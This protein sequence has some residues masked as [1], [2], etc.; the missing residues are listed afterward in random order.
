MRT[1]GI[2]ESM[3]YVAIKDHCD[4]PNPETC[5]VGKPSTG[6]HTR[7]DVDLQNYLESLLYD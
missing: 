1:A 7:K 6:N 5:L 4:V 3:K 2:D